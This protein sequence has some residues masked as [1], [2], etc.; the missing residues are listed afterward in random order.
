MSLTLYFQ[1]PQPHR[2]S[3]MQAARDGRFFR[4]SI[5]SPWPWHVQDRTSTKVFDGECWTLSYGTLGFQFC[6][7]PFFVA[8]SLNLWEWWHVRLS[9]VSIMWCHWI[10]EWCFFFFLIRGA[11]T[12]WLLTCS[13]T[14]KERLIDNVSEHLLLNHEKYATLRLDALIVIYLCCVVF[15]FFF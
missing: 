10:R 13:G 11:L 1:S 6:F 8:S 9:T 2:S 7:S 4:Q 5:C 12:L 14:N 15:F 3:S